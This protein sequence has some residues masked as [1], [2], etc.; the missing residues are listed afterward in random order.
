MET[1]VGLGADIEDTTV[2]VK[3]GKDST[4]V[5]TRRSLAKMYILDTPKHASSRF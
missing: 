4:R 2:Q 3:I 5:L 1:V